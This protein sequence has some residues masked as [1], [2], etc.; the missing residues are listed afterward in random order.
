V[1]QIFPRDLPIFQARRQSC[2]ALVTWLEAHS[3]GGCTL[4]EPR[5]EPHNTVSLLPLLCTTTHTCKRKHRC[6]SCKTTSARACTACMLL[7]RRPACCSGATSHLYP[8][9]LFIASNMTTFLLVR[10]RSTADLRVA[11][12][13]FSLLES[14]NREKRNRWAQRT[15]IKIEDQSR[16]SSVVTKSPAC[17]CKKGSCPDGGTAHPPAQHPNPVP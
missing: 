6:A 11:R 14:R 9:M 8:L 7:Y 17:L 13:S 10:A 15:N 2:L 4:E 5:S 1:S 12:A 16:D 3:N